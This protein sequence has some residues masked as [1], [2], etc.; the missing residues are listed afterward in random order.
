MKKKN[1]REKERDQA[2][3]SAVSVDFTGGSKALHSDV[4]GSWTGNPLDGD[5]PVQ[6]ADDL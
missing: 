6:D 2:R 4:Q 5:E 3:E 1:N